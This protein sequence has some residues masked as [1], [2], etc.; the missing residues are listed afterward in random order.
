MATNERQLASE[1]SESSEERLTDINQ[2]EETNN[3]NSLKNKE[4]INQ[5]FK[6]QNNLLETNY[7]VSK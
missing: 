4:L 1:T 5:S 2:E 3:R 7:N 6:L